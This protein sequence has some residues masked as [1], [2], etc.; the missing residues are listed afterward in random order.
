MG[1]NQSVIQGWELAADPACPPDDL[2]T[3]PA[4]RSSRNSKA[5]YGR[6]GCHCPLKA[7]TIDFWTTWEIFPDLMSDPDEFSLPAEFYPSTLFQPDKIDIFINIFGH[8]NP[9][10]R[11]AG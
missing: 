5:A 6:L 3:G 7:K 10:A 9:L 8:L 4:R 11:P 1:Q 2:A